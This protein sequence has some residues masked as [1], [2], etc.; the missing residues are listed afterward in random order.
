MKNNMVL[1]PTF[2]LETPLMAFLPVGF[3]LYSNITKKL[4][5]NS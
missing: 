5:R 2:P 4:N 3:Q 1:L